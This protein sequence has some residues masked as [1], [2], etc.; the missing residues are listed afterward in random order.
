MNVKSKEIKRSHKKSQSGS[1]P[2]GGGEVNLRKSL[3]HDLYHGFK[4]DGYSV[5][6][7]DHSFWL[8][9]PNLTNSSLSYFN[10]VRMLK[11]AS[12][13][14]QTIVDRCIILSCYPGPL[15]GF[16]L[17][18]WFQLCSDQILNSLIRFDTLQLH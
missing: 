4:C 15:C 5:H 16:W 12:W 8:L 7:F 6:L 17:F 2:L 11:A 9:A 1:C 14:R 18:G 10:A 3:A 13:W